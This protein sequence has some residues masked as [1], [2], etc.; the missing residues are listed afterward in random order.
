MKIL[1]LQ[2]DFPPYA[3]G[4]AGIISE[5]IAR[6]IPNT[7]VITT[8]QKKELEGKF[9]EN[10]ITVYR[11]YSNYHER[12]R[13][14][15]SLYNPKTIPKIES[16][17]KEVAP[18][19]IHAHNIHYHISYHSLKIAK[20]YTDKVFITIHD[21]MPFY[22]GSFTEF[23]KTGTYKVNSLI[24][25]KA[26]KK[27]WNPFHN[28]LVRY[29]LSFAKKIAVSYELKKA[30]EENNIKDISVIHNGIKIN[31]NQK[32]D[33]LK[34]LFQGRLSGA[35]GGDLIIDIMKKVVDSVP[36]AELLVAGKKDFYA[37]KMSKKAKNLGI[38]KNITFTGWVYDM[39]KVYAKSA[40]VVVPSVCFDSFPNGNL[41]AFAA[42]VPVV[43]T[44]FGGSKEIVEDGINGYIVN[45]F[46][47]D[48]FA[49]KIIT[50]LKDRELADRFGKNGLEKVRKD[51][52]VEKMVNKYLDLFQ[53]KVI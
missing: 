34:V 40:V 47:I 42:G 1:I 12:F 10:G 7:T 4:G 44:C 5:I 6:N 33:S 52:T 20:K 32:E 9:F 2:D 37:E 24:L 53:G 43:S 16:I 23:I 15:L 8:V 51:F 39:Q 3:N 50:L 18:D 48:L 21:I 25:F 28:I 41:E 31:E 30:L 13:S 46:N 49:E 11:I 27:R 19:I 17:I 35:K 22:Q 36:S 26:F 29:Y 38:E 45:P 14:Y